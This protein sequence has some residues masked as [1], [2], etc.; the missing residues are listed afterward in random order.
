MHSIAFHC[1]IYNNNTD[2]AHSSH[3]DF[4]F[5][6]ENSPWSVSRF[7]ILLSLSFS[8]SPILLSGLN[9]F[10]FNFSLDRFQ[11]DVKELFWEV[12]LSVESA[13]FGKY[14]HLINIGTALFPG[15]THPSEDMN[16]IHSIWYFLVSSHTF[17]AYPSTL[18]A[19][20][21]QLFKFSAMR[22]IAF[23]RQVFN[24]NTDVAHPSH[25][26]FRFPFEKSAWAVSRFKI[27]LSS[28]FSFSLILL[29]GLDR[30]FFFF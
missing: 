18:W 19:I 1:Q 14:I 3:S 25:S 16:T 17:T 15:Y 23:Y 9:R 24:N 13:C 5:L 4:Q 2:V 10:F 11:L 27:L 29:S 8:F 20:L 28:S 22:S 26:D 12:K 21:K 7:E 30:F 6:F